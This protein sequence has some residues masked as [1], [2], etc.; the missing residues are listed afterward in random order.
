MHVCTIQRREKTSVTRWTH[1][2]VCLF[3]TSG[4][5]EANAEQQ[6]FTA[7][8]PPILQHSDYRP[9]KSDTQLWSSSWCQWRAGSRTA[10]PKRLQVTEVGQNSHWKETKICQPKQNAKCTNVRTWLASSTDLVETVLAACVNTC[11]TPICSF[12][13]VALPTIQQEPTKKDQS[14]KWSTPIILLQQLTSMVI[15]SR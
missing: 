3:E 6:C 5:T 2:F 7:L 4:E 8:P 9:A 10:E 15:I 14:Q 11:H 1:Q 12:E 13:F